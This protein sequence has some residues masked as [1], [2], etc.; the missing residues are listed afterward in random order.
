MTKDRQAI[1]PNQNGF[2]LVEIMVTLAVLAIAATLVSPAIMSMAP[3]MRLRTATNE[4][5]ADLMRAKS[6][7]VKDNRNIGFSVTTVA[8][9]AAT[10]FASTINGGA[11]R[12]F[13]D[14]GGGDTTKAR[15]NTWDA[16]HVT[17]G[18][19]YPAEQILVDVNDTPGD[20]IDDLP[21]NVALCPPTIPPAIAPIAT[22]GFT[23]TGLLQNAASGSVALRISTVAGES[24]Y[25]IT[26]SP[27]GSVS[28]D[29][30]P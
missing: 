14:D 4:L 26:L 3:G 24:Y 28:T 15:N 9:P 29:K 16:A 10:K 1:L 25:H 17:G 5:H 23:A 6:R 2:T 13:V 7:A 21:D 8:C 18:I 19:N 22:T 27:A 20:G 12:I 11:Y 30:L